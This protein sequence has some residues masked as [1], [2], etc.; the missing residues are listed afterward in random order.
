MITSNEPGVYLAGE[1]GIRLENMILCKKAE[2]TA[3]GEFLEFETLT[4]VPFEREAILPERM[5]ERELSL[6]N[7]YH[8]TVYEKISPYL[9]KEE[10]AW[11]ENAAAPIAY[12]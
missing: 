12:K 11:L 5:T 4:L 1:Y 2:K 6:L 3:F 8:K 9:S 7:Q 10:A